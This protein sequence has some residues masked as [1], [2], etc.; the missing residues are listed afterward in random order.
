M[1]T[2][3]EEVLFFGFFHVVEYVLNV[4]VLFEFVEEFLDGGTLFVGHF[5]EVVG[6]AFELGAD[7]F[8]SV[9][10]EVFLDVGVVFECSVENDFL[11]VGFDFVNAAVDELEFEFLDVHAFGG[12]D[13]EH[14]LVVEEE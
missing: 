4:F 3:Y 2:V 9:V 11:F 14:A 6:D 10:L 7:D 1:L 12:F 8:V 5:L 13:L